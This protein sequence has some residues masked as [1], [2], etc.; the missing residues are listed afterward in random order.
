MNDRFHDSSLSIE[1][2]SFRDNFSPKMG[3]RNWKK[4]QS[5]REVQIFECLSWETMEYRLRLLL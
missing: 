1:S 3:S 5:N 2:L 4:V